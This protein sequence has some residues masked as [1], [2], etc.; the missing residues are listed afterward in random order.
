MMIS[1]CSNHLQEYKDAF[2]QHGYTSKSF[3]ASMKA[4]VMI[5]TKWK[6]L[7]SVFLLL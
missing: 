6:V 5:R 4:E 2:I 7:F 3:I 1:L